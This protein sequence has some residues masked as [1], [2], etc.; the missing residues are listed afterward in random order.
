MVP[1]MTPPVS[2]QAQTHAPAHVDG[3][4]AV[5]DSPLW[6]VSKAPALNELVVAVP[7]HRR[8]LDEGGVEPARR[9][10]FSRHQVAPARLEF[11]D[12]IRLGERDLNLLAGLLAERFLGT[13]RRRSVV[14]GEIERT[15]ERFTLAVDVTE[16]EGE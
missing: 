13:V 2:H 16:A 11:S 3:V 14:I 6:L 12:M 15:R 8:R 5:I 1:P 4:A 7:Q 10:A 9:L